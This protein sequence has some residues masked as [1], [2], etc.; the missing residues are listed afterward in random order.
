MWPWAT[1]VWLLESPQS[2]HRIWIILNFNFGVSQYLVIL[3]SCFCIGK[4]GL[5]QERYNIKKDWKCMLKHVLLKKNCCTVSECSN[6]HEL[7]MS[8]RTWMRN[9][10]ECEMRKTR[11]CIRHITPHTRPTPFTS[12]L[13]PHTPS[14]SSSQFHSSTIV[15]LFWTGV[16]SSF[17]WHFLYHNSHFSWDRVS[18]SSTRIVKET[19]Y[20]MLYVFFGQ[21]IHVT[22][23]SADV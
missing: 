7:P 11:K 19:S 9:E 8:V 15:L 4:H 3:Q 17:V 16:Y 6:F 22:V 5:L 20:L 14:P 21:V 2:Q 13:V 23:S 12:D 18:D 10:N 1:C